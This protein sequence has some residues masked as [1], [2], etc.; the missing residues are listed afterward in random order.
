MAIVN[1]RDSNFTKLKSLKKEHLK[2]FCKIYNVMYSA[3]MTETISA[4]LKDFDDSKISSDN[5]NSFIKIE[6]SVGCVRRGFKRKRIYTKVK[7]NTKLKNTPKTT[8]PE[9]IL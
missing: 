8:K 1:V 6:L 4:V 5:I 7:N 3:N 9:A 2:L